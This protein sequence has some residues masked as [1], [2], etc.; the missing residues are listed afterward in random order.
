MY[1]PKSR[2]RFGD[3]LPAA[4]P[5]ALGILGQ[6]S[7]PTFG[8]PGVT[9]FAP[10]PGW[11]VAPLNT[12]PPRD[13]DPDALELENEV[14]VNRRAAP[15]ENELSFPFPETPPLPLPEVEARRGGVLSPLPRPK[16]KPPPGPNDGGGGRGTPAIGD[17]RNELEIECAC[18]NCWRGPVSSRFGRPR[19]DRRVVPRQRLDLAP[20]QRLLYAPLCCTLSETTARPL[21][22]GAPPAVRIPWRSVA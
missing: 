10:P 2:G 11:F 12:D 22:G 4:R 14:C 15:L 5:A 6:S 20:P 19:P 13:D 17:T 21:V 8:S 16:W 9:P 7:S 18:E 1:V 3:D